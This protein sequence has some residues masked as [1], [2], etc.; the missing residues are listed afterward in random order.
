MVIAEIKH[1]KNYVA[2]FLELYRQRISTLT[3]KKLELL[4]QAAKL[5]DGGTLDKYFRENE[6]EFY[7][8]F[9]ANRRLDA[10]LDAYFKSFKKLVDIGKEYKELGSWLDAGG[11]A[12]AKGQDGALRRQKARQSRNFAHEGGGR[13]QAF[14]DGHRDL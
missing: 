13:R 6:E 11:T 7:A 9:N 10:C 3:R 14:A 4:S 8:F 2:L 1:L 5:L 12:Y